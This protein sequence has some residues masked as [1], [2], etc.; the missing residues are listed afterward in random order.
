[1]QRLL[2]KYPFAWFRELG[3]GIRKKASGFDSGGLLQ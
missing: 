1:M 2:I 3:K